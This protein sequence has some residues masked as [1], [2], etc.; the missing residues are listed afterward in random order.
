M[1]ELSKSS[2]VCS[3][4]TFIL[5]IHT[6]MVP[7]AILKVLKVISKSDDEDEDEKHSGKTFLKS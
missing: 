6:E 4:F 7:S 1:L 5:H 2:L 3:G